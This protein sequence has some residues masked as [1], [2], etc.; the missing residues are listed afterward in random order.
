MFPGT[1]GSGISLDS[2][3]AIRIISLLTVPVMLVLSAIVGKRTASVS[4][5]FN[6]IITPPGPFFAIWGIIYI[7][8]IICGVYQVVENVWSLGV[9]IIF[10]VVCLLNGLWVFIFDKATVTTS[11]IC[12]LMLFL[13]VGLN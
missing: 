1:Q 7:G 3:L 4:H 6:L 12:T 10:G 5:K 13:M 2:S 9:T 11:N 8:I